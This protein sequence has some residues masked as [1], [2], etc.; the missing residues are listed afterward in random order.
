MMLLLMLLLSL[1]NKLTRES[2]LKS[3]NFLK[4]MAIRT[5]QFGAF[6]FQ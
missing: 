2:D 6:L 1:K 4:G 5:A 3:Q